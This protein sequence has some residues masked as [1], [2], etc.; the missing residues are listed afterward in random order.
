MKRFH[1]VRV[2]LNNKEVGGQKLTSQPGAAE[3]I[4]ECK[5]I[6]ITKLSPIPTKK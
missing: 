5:Y 2:D 6:R 1:S 3:A 4:A